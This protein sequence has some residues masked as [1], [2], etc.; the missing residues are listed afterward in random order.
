MLTQA[1]KQ[2]LSDDVSVWLSDG[3]ISAQQIVPLRQRYEARSFGLLGVVKY[4]GISGGVFCL[5]GLLGLVGA[6]VGS[7]AFGAA[8]LISIG[9]GLI[10]A[11]LTLA[12]D[13]R[14]QY[15]VSSR[16]V[17]A[18]GAVTAACGVAVACKA[19]Q[20]SDNT[21][22]VVTGL[23]CVPVFGYLAYRAR[24]GFL[25]TLSVLSFFHW[26]GACESMF[27]RSTYEFEV[28][29]PET[30]CLAALLVFAIGVWHQ[31][32]QQRFLR[33][34][35]VYQTVALTYLNL[36]LLILSID[37]H[38]DT[39]LPGVLVFT[40]AALAQIVVGARLQSALLTGFGVTAVA[41]DL[42]TRYY[43]HF[44]A[45]LSLG[46]FLA[47]GGGIL[48]TLGLGIEHLAATRKTPTGA[49]S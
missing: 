34:Y 29:A 27:G 19:L 49:T 36:S 15:A 3:L 38:H 16:M 48:L 4:L 43:E 2:R 37:W 21:V 18:V 14:N 13:L 25:L 44:W 47:I 11:G 9:A 46:S 32:H 5:F 1:V 12:R 45:Q 28:D 24:D 30:M 10:A 23:C 17:T 33:F 40:L 31:G 41:L 8:L 35:V 7:A 42:F 6:M 22:I 26:V 20:A 39:A